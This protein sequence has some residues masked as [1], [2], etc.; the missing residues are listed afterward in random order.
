MDE[1]YTW[2]FGTYLPRR[3]PTAYKLGN[4]ALEGPEP[5]MSVPLEPP[6]NIDK[7]LRIIA[8]NSYQEYF[9]LHWE[10][11]RYVARAFIDT[12]TLI[13]KARN[14]LN[15]SVEQTNGP[16]PAY[17]KKLKMAMDRYIASLPKGK[18]VQRHSWNLSLSADLHCPTFNLLTILPISWMMTL[19]SVLDSVGIGLPRMKKEEVDPDRI[20]IRCERQT[21][22]R[23]MENDD[24]LVFTFH[25]FPRTLREIRVEG[26]GEAIADAILGL[27]STISH[28]DWYRTSIYWGQAVA[29]CL[30]D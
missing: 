22:H 9:F 24:T 5:G 28:L 20:T 11:D 14:K 1:F 8:Q 4:E 19:K 7:T 21:L 16:V 6:S 26:Q 12:F 23:L 3:Y 13:D 17:K 2:L 30:R 18:L 15:K 10:G 29:D 27:G 25:I